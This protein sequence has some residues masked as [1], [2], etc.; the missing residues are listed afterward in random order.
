MRHK[1]RRALRFSS[2]TPNDGMDDVNYRYCRYGS[3]GYASIFME[4][5]SLEVAF[6]V[7]SG[8]LIAPARAGSVSIRYHFCANSAL[9]L[10]ALS[11]VFILRRYNLRDKRS[12]L[13]DKSDLHIRSLSWNKI[14]RGISLAAFG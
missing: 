12:I 11:S 1:T 8:P 14:P 2:T 4:I 7:K 3:N 13:L 6:V 9:H 10:S 5:S